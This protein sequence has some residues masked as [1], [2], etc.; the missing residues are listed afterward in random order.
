MEHRLGR[1]AFV[2][3]ALGAVGL[4]VAG[5]AR[6]SAQPTVPDLGPPL[7]D[8]DWTRLPPGPVPATD[9]EGRRYIQTRLP[10]TV[11]PA[12][13]GGAGRPGLLAG[14]PDARSASYIVQDLGGPVAEIGASFAFGP[15][16][17]DG[18]L[19]LARFDRWNEDVGS[20]GDVRSSCHLGIT[21]TRWT[22]GVFRSPR[23]E[24]VRTRILS[25][26]IPKDGSVQTMRV[27][28][29][30]TTARVVEPDGSVVRIEDPRVSVSPRETYACWE[31][32]K[33]GPGAADLTFMRTW[34]R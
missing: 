6:E 21:P 4:A 24:V 10:A 32:F 25:T 1:R 19:C 23:I 14:L 3:G 26:P 18:S 30:G 29:Q 27:L 28:V 9:Q 16:H 13:V 5:C 33:L 7:T 20:R 12:V 2:V 34:A 11:P 15:G 31:S 8:T 17:D 22:Y